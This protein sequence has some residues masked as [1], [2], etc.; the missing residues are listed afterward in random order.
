MSDTGKIV[1]LI[2]ALAPT[3]DPEAIESAV[4]NWLED[5]PE[6]TTT[7]EDGSI[8][9]AKLDSDLQEIVDDVPSLKTEINSTGFSVVDGKLCMT[10]TDE[11]ESA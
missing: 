2:K 5:H 8:T 9:K 1:A 7:V 10:Y 11:E 3:A 6:A 4:A